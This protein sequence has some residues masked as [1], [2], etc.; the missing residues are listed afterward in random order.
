MPLEMKCLQIKTELN[1]FDFIV[2]V[3]PVINTSN[4]NEIIKK[5]K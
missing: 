5:K 1:F 4:S 3:I 2:P